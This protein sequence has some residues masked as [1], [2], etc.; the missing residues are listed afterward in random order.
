MV[1]ATVSE[2]VR[3]GH[4]AVLV[5]DVQRDFCAEDGVM[6]RVFGLDL[7]SIR[8][9]VPAL[10]VVIAG[11][12]RAGIPVVWIREVFAPARMRDNHRL[13]HGDEESLR[14]IREGSAGVDWYAGVVGP[15]PD[16]T[17]I[18]KWNYDAFEGPE[19]RRWLDDHDI[20]TVVLGGFTTNVCVE[21]TGRHAYLL[22]YYVVTLADC[23]GA[24]D[25]AEH[26]A[27]LHNLGRYFGSVVTSDVVLTAWG[28]ADQA[29]N[30]AASAYS[31]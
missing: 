21:T 27:A 14:L 17:V 19:L 5:I 18:T 10:N 9:A 8:A 22:G 31:G 7:R 6:S 13:I 12:R 11:A 29:A 1:L 26:E 23:T 25:P 30:P 4:T 28:V 16:E 20:R 3:P 15:N 2:Q 24:P